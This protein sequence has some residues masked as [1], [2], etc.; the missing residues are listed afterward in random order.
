MFADRLA[1]L[2]MGFV[3]QR[4]ERLRGCLDAAG[5]DS[6]IVTDP[7]NVRYL[8]GFTGSAGI[9]L[10]SSREAL[11]VTD[12]R[13]G[14]QIRDEIATSGAPVQTFV[15]GVAEQRSLLAD[16]CRGPVGL[17]AD[18]VTWAD[19]QNW[20]E[21]LSADLVATAGL[22]GGLRELKDE[23]ELARIE[24]AADIADEALRQLLL[25]PLRGLSERRVARELD[26]RV[27]ELG[28]AD[29]SF[30]TI[31]ASGPNSAAPHGRPTERVIAEGDL[32]ILDFGAVVDG[33][34]SDMTRTYSVGQPGDQ[35][36]A[37]LEVV[38][39][40]QEL[41]VAA[42]IGGAGCDSV[43]AACR[44]HIESQGCGEEFVHGTGHGVGL[45][46]HEAPWVN[47]RNP[48]PLYVGHVVTVEPGIYRPGVGG[49]RVED[50]L[51]VA[52]EGARPLTKSP[53]DPVLG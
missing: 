3:G 8:C 11:V 44:S 53:K 47:S 10:V 49:V 43:D 2:P 9:L 26:Q 38:T 29:R 25:A 40:A 35:T 15:G 4:V 22:V 46:I 32:L 45:A 16:R 27:L 18:C 39:T 31:C 5:V 36:A 12:G 24:L 42:V 23:G 1:D 33:Y 20:S 19:Q 50:T 6:L 21:V 7:D 30:E 51:V 14:E 28:A 17:E 41:A 48:A 37:M 52:D 13:Y 34:H